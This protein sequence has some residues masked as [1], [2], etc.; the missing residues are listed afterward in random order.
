MGRQQNRA[1]GYRQFI[2]QSAQR[3]HQSG[4]NCLLVSSDARLWI[5]GP[6]RDR[7]SRPT[8]E[9][10]MPVVAACLFL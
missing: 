8:G 1:E 3:R 9:H 6:P 10:R 4:G 2:C 7:S 5:E